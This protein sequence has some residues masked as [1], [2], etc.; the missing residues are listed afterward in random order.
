[1]EPAGGE[2]RIVQLETLR[3]YARR[4]LA[5]G[6]RDGGRG[7]KWLAYLVA[8]AER[9]EPQ[10]HSAT[11]L[12]WLHP[13]RGKSTQSLR[14]AGLCSGGAPACCGGAAGGR[15]L[16]FWVT[17]N[18][19]AETMRRLTLLRAALAAQDPTI[20]CGHDCSTARRRWPSTWVTLTR[21]VGAIRPHWNTPNAPANAPT[22]PYALDGLGRCRQPR[23]SRR[24]APF[25]AEPGARAGHRR[26]L[27]GRA[28][29]HEPGRDRPHRKKTTTSRRPA[30][31][32]ESGSPGDRRRSFFVAVA[33][34]NQ[35]QVC[36]HEG[37]LA[38][39]ERY[40][41]RSLDAGLRAESAGR[42][43]WKSWRTSLPVATQRGGASLWLCRRAA[44]RV[45]LCHPAGRP[46][47]S[48]QAA[49]ELL[50]MLGT[51]TTM[52]P[53]P[54]APARSGRRSGRLSD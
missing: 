15:A 41:R 25:R 26:P 23:R 10:L 48:R 3:D 12:D 38:A 43:G 8:L 4:Q 22:W 5:A 49:P 39:A 51:P 45:G 52:P 32:R 2:R 50:D 1:M 30:L 14:R 31:C 46:G 29:A 21:P 16:H 33:Q 47:R 19:L 7:E 37:N 13:P 6:W 54:P 34:I 28:H 27:A 44:A 9:A 40:L 18:H 17:R 11:Q 20:I 35:A 53:L 36:L 24:G 42:A